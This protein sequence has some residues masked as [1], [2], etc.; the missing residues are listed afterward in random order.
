MVDEAMLRRAD[1]AA[2][3]AGEPEPDASAAHGD[4]S[5]RGAVLTT[6]SRV[7]DVF[8]APGLTL[9]EGHAAL[10]QAIVGDRL[11]LALDATLYEA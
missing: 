3:A 7:G 6:S 9:T 5:R 1:A 4:A 10:H 2:R 8:T 11:R